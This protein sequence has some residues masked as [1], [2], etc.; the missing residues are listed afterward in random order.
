MICGFLHVFCV[1]FCWLL[2]FVVFDV[3]VLSVCDLIVFL[4]L[5]HMQLSNLVA[6]QEW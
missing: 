1:L 3:H 2:T 6:K 4:F 5:T